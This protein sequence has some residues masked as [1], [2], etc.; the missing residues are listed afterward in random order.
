M[1]GSLFLL[2]EG[3]E[4]LELVPRLYDSEALLQGLLARHPGLLVGGQIDPSSPRRWL[5]IKREAGVAANEAEGSRWYVD[6]LFLD[7]DGIPTL[8]EVKRST[9]TRIRREVVG[10]MLDYAANASVHWRLENIQASLDE[11][12]RSEGLTPEDAILQLVGPEADISDFWQRVKTNL[13]AGRIRLIFVADIIPPELAR[14]VEFLNQQ[15][16]PAEVLAV[17]VRRFAG[18]GVDGLVPRL[19]GLT[20]EAQI[21]K[22]G[23]PRPGSQW[24]E[25]RFFSTL[26]EK[27]G[28]EAASAV[29]RIAEW[30]RTNGARFS[31]GRGTQ[32]GSL[33]PVW[34]ALGEW[35]CPVVFYTD[36]PVEL[37]FQYLKERPPFDSE[38]LR[39]EFLSRVRKIE[40]VDISESRLALRPSFPVSLLVS[41]SAVL[42]FCEALDWFRSSVPSLHTQSTS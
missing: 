29:R 24:T 13:Q 9:D 36:G 1:T 12:C 38:E 37:Q 35:Y 2:R 8:V 39:R 7:Q 41:G 33:Y 18:A 42:H 23:A 28:V 21:R 20:Q 14:L 40:G 3:D 17:E 19:I 26:Q 16:D 15:M 27:K 4:L 30:C 22:A 32:N 5:L 6:H 11:R 34:D 10:Q 31:F 25:E